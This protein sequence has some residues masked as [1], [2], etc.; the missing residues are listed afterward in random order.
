MIGNELRGLLHEFG[1]IIPQGHK[2]IRET[3]PELLEDAGNGL[4]PRSR[5]LL[6]D[7]QQHWLE[8]D[9][10]ILR[11]DHELESIARDNPVCQ[12]LQTVPGIGP[13]NAALLYSHAGDAGYFASSNTGRVYISIVLAVSHW[14]N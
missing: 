12:R 10:R 8:R 14:V 2:A 6:A 11:Y 13:V 5:E 4:A 1:L 9:Q 3:V 7:L